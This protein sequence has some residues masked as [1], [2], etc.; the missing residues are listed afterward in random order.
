MSDTESPSESTTLAQLIGR[1]D[2]WFN[3]KLH[4]A[5]KAKDY[6]E[7]NNSDF[8]MLANLNCGQTYPSELARR[9]GISR[10]AVYKLLKNLEKKEIVTL[11]T[12]PA[13]GNSKIII[14]T[15]QGAQMI[16]EAVEV[17]KDIEKQLEATLGSTAI[18]QLRCALEQ[19]WDE[20][21]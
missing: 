19:D 15:P 11:E 14:I 6:G 8:L 13:K 17:L 2:L 4:E 3:K 10:Q 18:N 21:Q 1:A 12:D 7:F 20:P 5:L 16:G 9:I